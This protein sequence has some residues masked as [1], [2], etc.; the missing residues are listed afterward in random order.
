MS[1]IDREQ[2]IEQL[3]GVFDEAFPHP[4]KPWSYFTDNIPGAGY[5]ELLANLTADEVSRSRCNSSIAAHV[6]HMIFAL[7]TV[8]AWI[9]GERTFRD[10]TS[11]WNVYEVESPEWERMKSHLKGSYMDARSALEQSALSSPESFGGAV[12]M[13]AHAAYHLSAIHHLLKC[14]DSDA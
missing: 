5:E 7:E 10:W 9:R 4:Q 6:N 14:T 3:V 11:S 1:E 2:I 12:G 8:A 13:I